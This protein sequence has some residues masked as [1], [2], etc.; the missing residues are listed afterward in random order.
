MQNIMC[1][2]A[3]HIMRGAYLLQQENQHFRGFFIKFICC[4]NIP[5]S[6]DNA[7]SCVGAWES[8]RLPSAGDE[9]HISVTDCAARGWDLGW[10]D[11]LMVMV[12][13]I[14]KLA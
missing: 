4:I 11:G 3:E 12:S 9:L 6:K 1:C 8:K 10:E 13:Y 2:Q 5:F 14:F 7:T